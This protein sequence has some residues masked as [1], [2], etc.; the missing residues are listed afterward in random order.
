[1]DDSDVDPG[2][3]AV[4]DSDGLDSL[5]DM[6]GRAHMGECRGGWSKGFL[7]TVLGHIRIDGLE[8]RHVLVG[9]TQ[10]MSTENNR[11]RPFDVDSSRRL[12]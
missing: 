7:A 12:T 3:T 11:F 5:D 2:T 8:S 4:S 1:M 9:F 10:A 6:K